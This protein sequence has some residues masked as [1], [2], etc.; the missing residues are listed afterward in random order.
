MVLG[1]TLV[2]RILGTFGEKFM[3]IVNTNTQTDLQTDK[4]SQQ[5]AAT[6]GRGNTK[7]AL[8]TLLRRFTH[9]HQYT[10]TDFSHKRGKHSHINKYS[11][12]LANRNQEIELV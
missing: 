8:I 3:V 10:D 1:K 7:A 6:Q 11:V 12:L 9:N 4:H 2:E 5:H